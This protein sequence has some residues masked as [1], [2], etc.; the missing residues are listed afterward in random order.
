MAD[1]KRKKQVCHSTSHSCN[2]WNNFYLRRGGY[3]FISAL[4]RRGLE[5]HSAFSSGGSVTSVTK[6]RDMLGTTS[7]EHQK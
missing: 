6:L 1:C 7:E 3:E 4:P 5:S 2:V